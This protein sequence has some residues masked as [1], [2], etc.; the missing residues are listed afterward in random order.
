MFS[1][2]KLS[3][4]PCII[5]NSTSGTILKRT[6]TAVQTG[7]CTPVFTEALFTTSKTWK[8]HKCPVVVNEQKYG[9]NIFFQP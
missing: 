8:Q 2:H 4:A 3:E 9:I 7:M 5:S 1:F 6:E